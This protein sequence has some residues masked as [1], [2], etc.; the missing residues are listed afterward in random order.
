M[1]CPW[2][3]LISARDG[4]GQGPVSGKVASMRVGHVDASQAPRRGAARVL[5][6]AASQER[7]PATSSSWTRRAT[8][9]VGAGADGRPPIVTPGRADRDGEEDGGCSRGRPRVLGVLRQR[10][11]AATHGAHRCHSCC[12]DGRP[13]TVPNCVSWRLTDTRSAPCD[14]PPS[15]SRYG[16]KRVPSGSAGAWRA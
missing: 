3:L 2:R 9:A 13:G 8:L 5:H 12:L 1:V 14:D 10:L 16:S 11:A 15:L 6:A 7:P 4:R